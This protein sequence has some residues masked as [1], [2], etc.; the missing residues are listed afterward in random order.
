VR[1]VRQVPRNPAVHNLGR[2]SSN[3]GDP[4]VSI[5][6]P[7]KAFTLLSDLP[8]SEVISNR[9]RRSRSVGASRGREKEQHRRRLQT[10]LSPPKTS[11]NQLK[12]HPPR[13]EPI[14]LSPGRPTLIKISLPSPKSSVPNTTRDSPLRSPPVQLRASS[15]HSGWN[16][17][18][19]WQP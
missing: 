4:M 5:S 19:S 12:P 7:R 9:F 1:A 14:S 11:V 3:K 6:P 16:S 18:H 17:R 8:A 15:S 13:K 10:K 2:L